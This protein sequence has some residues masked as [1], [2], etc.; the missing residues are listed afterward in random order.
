M[1]QTP[2]KPALTREIL[3]SEGKLFADIESIFPEPALYGVTDGK[4]IGTYFEHKFK[5][6]LAA[7]YSYAPGNSA[8]GI[9]FPSIDVDMKVTSVTQPQS[10]CPF[11]SARQKI[12][13]LG[14]SVLVFV[15]SKSDDPVTRTGLLNIQHCIFVEKALTAD[16]QT[17]TG[18]RAIFENDGNEDDLVAFMQD[19]FLPV[20]DIEA[21]VI[22]KQLLTAP[23]LPIGYLTISNAL[24][25]R[26]QYGRVIMKAGS[27]EGILR[28]R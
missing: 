22:A 19:R 8:S 18:I 15:Y 5:A 20:E 2:T 28:L 3:C 1:T 25:W 17:T 24:Q 26:L 21:H 27:V 12:F 16:Y 9:D 23:D 13:G 11:S 7:K 14:Y 6:Y 4:S 10:S